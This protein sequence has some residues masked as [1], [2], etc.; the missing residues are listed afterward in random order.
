VHRLL[1]DTMTRFR[2]LVLG[3]RIIVAAM[4]SFYVVH[5]FAG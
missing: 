4:V 2:A 1:E 5:A 3:L